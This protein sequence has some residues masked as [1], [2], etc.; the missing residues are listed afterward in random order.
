[1]HRK[2]FTLAETLITLGIIGVVAALTIPTLAKHYQHKVLETSF[3]KGY[4]S[5]NQVIIQML[6][7]EGSTPHTH[8]MSVSSRLTFGPLLQKYY[9][10]L[11]DCS[12]SIWK[13]GDVNN[14]TAGDFNNWAKKTYKTFD[15]TKDFSQGYTYIDDGML[16]TMDGMLI[17]IDNSNYPSFL[18]SID[19]NG[20]KA[21]NA[22]GHDLFTFILDKDAGRLLPLEDGTC[23][24]DIPSVINGLSCAKEA[25]GD[26]KYFDK[27]P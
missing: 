25:L 26:S 24:K 21:P 16:L 9:K 10:K 13:C 8:N 12:E 2:G 4:S 22:W 18:V 23:D 19:T 15:K 1:M 7:E 17:Y 14:E 3:K 27:L 5:L 20:T 11:V 6:A